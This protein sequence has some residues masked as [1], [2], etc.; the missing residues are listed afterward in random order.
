MTCE[1]KCENMRVGTGVWDELSQ[2]AEFLSDIAVKGHAREPIRTVELALAARL[3]GESGQLLGGIVRTMNGLG[4][5]SSVVE[6][7]VVSCPQCDRET[8]S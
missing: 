6:L 5:E 4:I 8:A 7:E 1:R 2:L 3:M